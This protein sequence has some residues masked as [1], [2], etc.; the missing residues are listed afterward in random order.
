MVSRN[1]AEQFPTFKIRSGA[2]TGF[3]EL[4]RRYQLNPIRLLALE[5]LSPTVL[6]S[7]DISI[8]YDSLIRVLEHAATEADDPLFS[9]R[10]SLRHGIE[11]IGPLGLLAGQCNS[12]AESLETFKKYVHFHAQGIEIDVKTEGNKAL[13]TYSANVNTE[14]NLIQLVQLGV[15]RCFNILRDLRPEGMPV[16]AVQFQHAQ[17]APTEDYEK[18]LGAR[19]LFNQPHN[20]VI[21]PARY[22]TATPNRTSSEVRRYFETYIERAGGKSEKPLELQVTQLIRELMPTGEATAS[23]V[24]KLLG[25][26]IRVLQR[27]LQAMDTSFRS[28]LETVRYELAR[29]W[30]TNSATPLTDLALQ[31]GYSELSAFSRAF[32][33]WSGSSPQ[34]WQEE[35]WRKIHGSPS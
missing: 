20:A 24:A 7:Y 17:Q 3:A 21:F 4:C 34:Q 29:E 32:K 23:T 2:L 16:S 11:T 28:L 22:L 30:M 33:R 14:V 15:G 31:L 19:V 6:R 35:Q 13:L 25:M 10:L 9:L 12:L 26:N 27:E 18:L 5:D 8:P 1:M